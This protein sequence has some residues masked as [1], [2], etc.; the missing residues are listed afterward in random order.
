MRS[1][2]TRPTTHAGRPVVV[3]VLA[4][5]AALLA[6]VAGAGPAQSRVAQVAHRGRVL[7]GSD[8]VTHHPATASGF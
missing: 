2:A 5:P 3:S 4:T 8:A 7:G 6:E 1:P